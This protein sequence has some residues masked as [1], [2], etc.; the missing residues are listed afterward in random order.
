MA[1]LKIVSLNC[2]GLG[3]KSK[4]KSVFR[5][6]LK[7]KADIILLQETHT[8][9]ESA[10][11]YKDEWSTYSSHHDSVWHSTDEDNASR[12]CG[13]AVLVRSFLTSPILDCSTD[14]KGRLL[15]VKTMLNNQLYQLLNIYAPDNFK[16]RPHFFKNI[17]TFIFPD[18]TMIVGGDFNMVEDTVMDR[19]GGLNTSR[20]KAGLVDLLAFKESHSLT[21]MW[22]DKNP[23]QHSYTW[24][25]P[26][27]TL[28]SR[29]DRFYLP[30]EIET[31]YISQQHFPV[32]W[33]DHA[34]V[35]LSIDPAPNE[36]RGQ[37]YWKFNTSLLLDKE[38]KEM[39]EK[40]LQHW[41]DL[42]PA[43][44][45][46]QKWW[47]EV[48]LFIKEATISYSTTRNRKFRH[49]MNLTLQKI[50][51]Q[52]MNDDPDLQSLTDA[53]EYLEDLKD[54]RFQGAKVRSRDHSLVDGEK[55][56][57]YFYAREAIRKK[58]STI[59]TIHKHI[60]NDEY[61]VITDQG[62]ILHETKLYFQDLFKKQTLEP[63]LQDEL[64]SNVTK[65]LPVEIREKMDAIVGN[66]E[67]LSGLKDCSKNSSPG[68]D[69][70]P[71]EFYLE[72]WD[73]IGGS[74]TK[75]AQH[76]YENGLLPTTSQRI[77]LITLIHKRGDLENLDNWRPIS[78]LC[79]D[80]KILSKLLSIRMKQA[81]PHILHE[82]QTCG[83]EER[84]I[85]ENMYLLRDIINHA[86][87]YRKPLYAI[88]LDFQKAFDKVDHGFLQKT[89]QTF[90][91]GPKYINFIVSSNSNSWARVQNNG[92]HSSN[93]DLE[94]GLKQGC[95]QS[96][97]LYGVINEVFTCN[98]RANKRIKGFQLPS[99]KE[100]IGESNVCITS[101]ADDN[102]PLLSTPSSI[103]HLFK[104]INRF[105]RASGC[106]INTAKTKGL[107]A[108]GVTVPNTPHPIEWNPTDGFKSLGAFFFTDMAETTKIS[109]EYVITG[110]EKKVATHSS[111]Q[112]SFKGRRQL[113][114]SKIISKAVHLAT[115][116]PP[117]PWAI[118]RVNKIFF[119]FI[120]NNKTPQNISRDILNLRVQHGGINAI[121]FKN[122][123][124]SLQINHLTN[125]LNPLN[126][127]LWLILPRFYLANLVGT[128]NVEWRF[129]LE[130][131]FAKYNGTDPP[132]HFWCLIYFLQDHKQK[133]TDLN[134]VTTKGIYNIFLESH[135]RTVIFKC[136]NYWNATLNNFLPWIRVWKT[137]YRSLDNSKVQDV[138]YK[139]LHGALADGENLMQSNQRQRGAGRYDTK[140]PRCH[141]M[142]TPLHALFNCNT[143]KLVWN[144]YMYIFEDLFE[145]QTTP[146]Q[147]V[148]HA[149]RPTDANKSRVVS[150]VLNNIL[151]EVWAGRC[152]HK[153]ED[154]LPSPQL[155][156]AKINSRIKVVYRA[157][158][159]LNTAF[160]NKFAVPNVFC[161]VN[162][163]SIVFNLPSPADVPPGSNSNAPAVGK[164]PFTQ[165]KIVFLTSVSDG[166]DSSGYDTPHS[167]PR[168]PPN[169]T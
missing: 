165:R 14:S 12:S 129:L 117:P 162:G 47:E 82:T 100:T 17:P 25:S 1:P 127:S 19:R 65:R 150:T 123:C 151:H 63:K 72:F 2:R 8:T 34:I 158:Y 120:Y 23:T 38:Y 7:I 32:I 11:Q 89:L 10:E 135:R 93:L 88:S 3:D 77:S 134:Q 62:Q 92:Y 55:P 97:Q 44:P 83:V 141:I 148:F 91:F 42:T 160:E 16:Q 79:C 87:L 113:A 133:F 43:Y 159:R 131:R 153:F 6:L 102:T 119:D 60:D 167:P 52:T 106:N 36:F 20:H 145:R 90:G 108:G 68:I 107:T 70:I 59:K 75:W 48:K 96:Q 114:H 64:L 33:S 143:A 57:R 27:R 76:V 66:E 86:N 109:W 121:D 21:D 13:V 154:N 122:H 45:N 40:Q 126:N 5:H 71:Y 140:C 35:S 116:I 168:L 78:L 152:R 124:K 161:E 111:R 157:N 46:I 29:L 144:M 56:T 74:F 118:R 125:I 132:L 37:G 130:N 94:R 51:Q 110:M 69:G 53:R 30:P 4:R 112:L 146:L 136:A 105:Q 104:E 61:E 149:D 84:Q 156:I 73:I 169:A 67:L 18:S 58:T 138:H 26:D 80:Y 24:F 98:V 142:E 155:T 128:R 147:M 39:M 137:T 164:T 50:N 85:F 115:V 22:R 95:Q 28:S 166:T 163:E 41:I 49:R 15:T 81:L 9:Q 54:Q 31:S 103:I 101:Y 99:T 139:L